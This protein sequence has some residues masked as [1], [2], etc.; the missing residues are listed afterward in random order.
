MYIVTV[1]ISRNRGGKMLQ[2]KYHHKSQQGSALLITTILLSALT[3]IISTCLTLVSMQYDLAILRRN[4]S[5][6]YYLAKSALEKQV[7][8]MNKAIETQMDSLLNRINTEYIS[9]ADSELVK[10][11]KRIRYHADT[12]TLAIDSKVLSESIQKELYEYLK[13]GYVTETPSG[14]YTGKK[15][16]TYV[17]QGDRV[18]NEDY[19]EIQVSTYTTDKI[20]MDLSSAYQFRVVATAKT[21][22]VSNPTNFYDLQNLEAIITIQVPLD[23]KNQIHERYAFYNDEIP[24][25]L[26]SP[27]LCF[28]DVIVSTV[29]KL[30]IISGDVRISGA[31]DIE[32]YD[33]GKSYPEANQNGG[34]IALNG[35]QI[36]I[37]DNLYCT[38]N[39]LATNGWG[40]AYKM[41]YSKQTLIE[42]DGDVIAHTLGL[43]DDY[44]DYSMNQSPFNV[45]NQ[46]QNVG[47][48]V[49]RNVMVDDD[50][51]IGRWIKDCTIEVGKSLFGIN[52][53]ADSQKTDL[54]NVNP[55]QSSSVFAQGQGS[56]IKAERMY[57][58]GQPYISLSRDQKPLKLWESIGE[59]F[60]GLASFGGYATYEEK[61]E[62]PYYFEIFKEW[63]DGT[64]IE[65]D[66]VNTY[67]VARVSGINT[68][69][70]YIGG[71]GPQ[72]GALCQAVFGKNQ[73][74]A[75]KFFYQGGGQEKFSEFMET[76]NGVIYQNYIKQVQ[77]IIDHLSD[78][79]GETGVLGY[80]KYLGTT[81]HSNY[82]GL[83]GYMTLMR[84]I[85]YQS[86][87]ET[88]PIQA[89]FSDIIKKERLPYSNTVSHHESWSYETPLCITNGGEI[90]ISKFYISEEKNGYQPYPTIIVSNGKDTTQTLKLVAS[91]PRY[92][93]FKGIIISSGP[94]EIA[95]DMNIE[96][97][98]IIGGPE[99]RP[100]SKWGDRKE[101][102]EGKHAGLLISEAEVTVSY[103]PHIITELMVKDHKKYRAILDALYLTDYSESDLS[104]IMK[105][106][107]NYTQ[108]A[109]KYSHESILEV[110]PEGIGVEM[111]LLKS[112]Q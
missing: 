40:G 51:M 50:V 34:M 102:F 46:V 87:D 15:P 26:K 2:I 76:G 104:N 33:S 35:G 58:A 11:G 22:S 1:R 86:F 94:V 57:V 98:I 82:Q 56:R 27:L 89:R 9:G 66:F 109:L 30:N 73:S 37:A 111:T 53:G 106:Q 38:N 4:T 92:K 6:T 52:G 49:G 107:L 85:F 80:R 84:S 75:V 79:W 17:V 61:S 108:S 21:K 14:T 45:A 65:T 63:I 8:T 74:N 110:Q 25:I 54:G 103:D 93:K 5:N 39:V 19:T 41:P 95:N 64:K 16:I 10:N 43:V 7:D 81:P 101:I 72:V 47:I 90:D 62:N 78:Y 55:N 24:E 20:G 83:R 70:D 48:K 31:Q 71:L 97:V 69:S 59:P 13:E 91:H 88:H 28:S 77:H 99:S 67:A 60:S 96:G 12:Y 32:S 44:Y 23:I 18:E 100:H 29:G 3:I 105:K 36:K 42:V 68:N 112:V